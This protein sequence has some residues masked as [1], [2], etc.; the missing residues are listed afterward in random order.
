MPLFLV[1]PA[2]TLPSPDILPAINIQLAKDSVLIPDVVF[3]TK[4]LL[5]KRQCQRKHLS[6]K[7]LQKSASQN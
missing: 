2:A 7:L 3:E 4:R 5:Q 1:T 6:K